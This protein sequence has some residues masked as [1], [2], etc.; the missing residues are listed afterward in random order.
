MTVKQLIEELKGLDD[1]LNVILLDLGNDGDGDGPA[2]LNEIIEVNVF[3]KMDDLSQ[4]NSVVL[5]FQSNENEN[6]SFTSYQIDNY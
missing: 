1:D 5:C 4:I 3:S 2:P 6:G